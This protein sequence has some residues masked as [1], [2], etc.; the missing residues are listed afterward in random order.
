MSKDYIIFAR[1]E[2]QALDFIN[3]ELDP[4]L[5]HS[6]Y[7]AILHPKMHNP[8]RAEGW[9]LDFEHVRYILLPGWR[10]DASPEYLEAVSRC[11]GMP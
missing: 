10:K 11:G 8:A 5:L 6:S 1:S 7:Y 2:E 4:D 9:Q 3:E